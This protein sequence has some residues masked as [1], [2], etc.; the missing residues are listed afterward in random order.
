[1]VCWPPVSLRSLTPR[2]AELSRGRMG[3]LSRTLPHLCPQPLW[4]HMLLLI[5]RR[6]GSGFSW[7]V[8]FLSQVK[9]APPRWPWRIWP[10]SEPS[11]TALSSIQVMPFPRSMLFSWRPIPRY[12]LKGTLLQTENVSVL[13]LVSCR[14]FDFTHFFSAEG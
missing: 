8:G 13:L 1:M 12:F 4:Q 7:A 9:T 6:T 5:S 3:Q 10:C 14:W 2:V 11:Q